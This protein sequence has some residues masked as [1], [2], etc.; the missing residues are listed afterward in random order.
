MRL[1]LLS[2]ALIML[3]SACASK[4]PVDSRIAEVTSGVKAEQTSFDVYRKFQGP[5]HALDKFDGYTL[6]RSWRSPTG[7]KAEHQIYVHVVHDGREKVFLSAS[8]PGG[9]LV[10]LKRIDSGRVCED[11]SVRSECPMFEDIGIWLETSELKKAAKN[12]GI[13]LR[14]N[15]K[16]GDDVIVR[17]P[18]W[19][20][21][22]YI[23][24]LKQ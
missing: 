12:N 1:A 2:T 3:M 6:I 16:R 8:R 5:E 15:A 20:L 13:V 19:Y 4:A 24:A 22:G 18:P 10:D 17:I 9:K 14:V 7:P 21:K 23:E 11:G